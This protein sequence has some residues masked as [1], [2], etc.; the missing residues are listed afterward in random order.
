MAKKRQGHDEQA[1]MNA[2]TICR[3]TTRQVEMA[4]ALGMNPKKLARLRPGPQKRWK[5]PVGEFIEELYLKRFGGDSHDDDPVAGFQE[6]TGDRTSQV[7]DLVCYLKNLADDLRM[8]LHFGSIGADV[9]SQ[10]RSELQ[11]VATALETGAA[12]S[13]VP[14][15]PV[16]PRPARRRS[17]WQDDEGPFDDDEIPF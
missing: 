12:T 16:P 5:L 17:Q 7:S 13:K 15:I 1:W 11:E 4:R 14:A 9:V 10:V 2:K 3:L 8:W 6:G